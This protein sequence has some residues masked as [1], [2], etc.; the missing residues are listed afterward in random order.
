MLTKIN[1]FTLLLFIFLISCDRKINTISQNTTSTDSTTNTNDN[2]TTTTKSGGSSTNNTS[3]GGTTDSSSGGGSTTTSPANDCYANGVGDS[4]NNYITISPIIGKGAR[5]GVVQWSSKDDPNF[6]SPGDQELFLTDSRL[7]I[8]VLANSSPG[9][10]RTTSTNLSC[11]QLAVPYKKLQVKVGI[12]IQGSYGYQATH[13]FDDIDVGGCSEV[14]EFSITSTSSP[15]IIEI[16]ET[17]WDYSC[18]FDK[19]SNPDLYCPWSF[20]WEPDC[21]SVSLQVATDHTRDIPH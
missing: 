16:L 7:N 15:V 2:S 6:Q 11:E 5:S 13:I 10:G 18:T 8:R 21:F 4:A 20:V 9:K 12:K 17:K 1:L 19:G 14:Y 3:N